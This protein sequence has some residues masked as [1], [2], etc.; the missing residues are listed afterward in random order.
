MGRPFNP[1]IRYKLDQPSLQDLAADSPRSPNPH[2]SYERHQRLFLNTVSSLGGFRTPASP[3]L[4]PPRA[5]GRRPKPF[6]K[7]EALA[8]EQAQETLIEAVHVAPAAEP[9]I[10]AANGVDVFAE[11]PE[12]IRPVRSRVVGKT[13]RLRVPPRPASCAAARRP[14]RT[15]FVLPSPAR[16]DERSATE[17]TAPVCRRHHRE[18]H[19]YGDEA[20]WWAAVNVDPVPIAPALWRRTRPDRGRDRRA[21]TRSGRGLRARM[22]PIQTVLLYNFSDPG[23]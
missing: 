16:S 17:Y 6:T 20:S 2:R 9:R 7:V 22:S 12:E 21:M 19:G 5:R 11:V 8:D 4:A 13:I 18:L 3:C 15:I 1:R 23:P 10:E 14:T